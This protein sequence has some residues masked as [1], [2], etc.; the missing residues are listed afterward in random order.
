MTGCNDLLRRLED[1]RI[2]PPEGMGAAELRAWLDGY[3]KC[4]EDARRI[5]REAMGWGAR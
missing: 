4:M 1:V 2:R 3:L 5:V